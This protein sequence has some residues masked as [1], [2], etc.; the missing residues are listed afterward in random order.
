MNQVLFYGLPLNSMLG[1][2]ADEIYTFSNMISYL[3]NTQ[4]GYYPLCGSLLD[5]PEFD[6][7]MEKYLDI[8]IKSFEDEAYNDS[9]AYIAD[10]KEML[11]LYLQLTPSQQFSFL[12]TLNAFYAMNIPPLAFDNSGEYAE[13]LRASESEIES[14]CIIMREGL[15]L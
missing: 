1:I 3:S 15:E 14:S 5:R 12:G 4:G 13:M 11:A 7:L 8:I 6:A 9:A 2:A 10:V